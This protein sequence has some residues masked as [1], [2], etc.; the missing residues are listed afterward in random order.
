[1]HNKFLPIK[2]ASGK[3]FNPSEQRISNQIRVLILGQ[4]FYPTILITQTDFLHLVHALACQHLVSLVG[5]R[6]TMLRIPL[7]FK[8]LF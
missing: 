7:I 8:K 4:E 3:S 2:L 1:M 6:E 5:K